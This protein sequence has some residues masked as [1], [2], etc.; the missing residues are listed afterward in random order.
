MVESAWRGSIVD[1]VRVKV[2]QAAGIA[3]RDFRK[4]K[5]NPVIEIDH[6]L[7]VDEDTKIILSGEALGILDHVGR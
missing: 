2:W 7:L 6:E 4:E 1:C 5:V 3:A